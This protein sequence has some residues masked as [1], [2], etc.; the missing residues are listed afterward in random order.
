MRF[1]SELK[2]LGRLVHKVVVATYLDNRQTYFV[3]FDI[4]WA[5]FSFFESGLISAQ[6]DLVLKWPRV[7]LHTTDDCMPPHAMGQPK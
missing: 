4:S 1:F 3:S 7:G 6:V 2:L 5:H